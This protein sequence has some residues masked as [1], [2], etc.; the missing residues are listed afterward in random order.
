VLV[1]RLKSIAKE[2]LSER[3]LRATLTAD[4]EVSLTEM[5]GELYEKALRF[6]EPTGYGNPNPVFM[7]RNVKV[8]NARTVGADAK[9]LKLQLEDES[10]YPHDAIGFRLG[11]WQKKMPPRV[12]VLFTYEPNEFNRRVTYQL[13]L[14][15]LKP[16]ESSR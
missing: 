8:K 7:A 11:E 14:K 15:D 3:D 4:V 2:Q 12:D 16:A 9:H 5:R 10:G 13:N 1:E 6:L